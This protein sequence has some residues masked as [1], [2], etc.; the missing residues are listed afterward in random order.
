MSTSTP[1]FLAVKEEFEQ[2]L[3][4]AQTLQTVKAPLMQ[5]K[6]QLH[7]VGK[8]AVSLLSFYARRTCL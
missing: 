3:A 2:S 7:D 4:L 5:R 1:Q 6:H 8:A